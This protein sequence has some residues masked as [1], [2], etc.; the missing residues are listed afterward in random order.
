VIYCQTSLLHVQPTLIFT[1]PGHCFHT[2]KLSNM[3]SYPD[4]TNLRRSKY[5]PRDFCHIVSDHFAALWEED[6]VLCVL[7]ARRTVGQKSNPARQC[8]CIL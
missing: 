1:L 7:L 3:P 4:A 6:C 8:W 2:A 5:S